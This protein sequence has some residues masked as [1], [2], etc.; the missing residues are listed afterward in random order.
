MKRL[1]L[2]TVLIGAAYFVN[3][4]SYQTILDRDSSK[5]YVGLINESLLKS[6]SAYNWFARAQNIY[7]PKAPV[8][9]TFAA[10]KDSV[11]FM[12]IVGTWCEDSHYVI[13]RFFSILDSAGFD[14]DKVTLVAVDRTKKDEN[15]LTN[16][17]NVTNVPTIIVYKKGKELGRVVEYGKTGR[18]DEELAALLTKS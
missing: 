14:N 16:V 18:F 8:V 9:K 6:D 1:L 13:P 5:M 17:L 11:S 10:N 15:N 3:A 4:Q 7:K 2:I 12:V